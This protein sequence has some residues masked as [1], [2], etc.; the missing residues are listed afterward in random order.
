MT[1]VRARLL[2]RNG[3][4]SAAADLELDLDDDDDDDDDGADADENGD[5]AGFIVQ[6][7]DNDDDERHPA[8]L[9]ARQQ[10]GTTEAPV[11][12]G[13]Y[14]PGKKFLCFWQPIFAC[15]CPV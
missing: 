7:D 12:A 6:D 10:A 1:Q 2:R 8:V 14:N 3:R 15:S 5:L 4:E 11:I 13:P 9:F